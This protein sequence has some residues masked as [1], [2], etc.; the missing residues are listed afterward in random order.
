MTAVFDKS[1][2]RFQ[3]PENWIIAEESLLQWPRSVSLQCP[4]GG[5]WS[6]MMYQPGTES[7]ALLDETLEQMRAEYSNLES[8]EITEEFEN[9]RGGGYEMYFYCLDF[10]V[11]AKVIAIECGAGPVFLLLWQAEDREFTEYE[12]V[13]RAVTISLLRSQRT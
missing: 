5:F 12:P 9:A 13:F 4:G 6:L 11:R 7:T 3:Y 8:A 1:G 2:I 10:L